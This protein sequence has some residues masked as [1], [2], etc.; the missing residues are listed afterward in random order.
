VSTGVREE[1]LQVGRSWLKQTLGLTDGQVIPPYDEAPKPPKPFI[2]VS[3]P[4]HFRKSGQDEVLYRNEAG[5]TEVKVQG[6]RTSVVQLDGFGEGAIPWLEE[7]PL[8][9]RRPSV[10]AL[11]R[12]EGVTIRPDGDGSL[13]DSTTTLAGSWERRD[14]QGYIATYHVTSGWTVLGPEFAELDLSGHIRDTA[15]QPDA[16][17]LDMDYTVQATP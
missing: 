6:G 12:S 15:Q 4:V 7:A 9:L 5:N 8:T 1:V 10:R 14:T 3:L 13:Q 2:M 17:A 11:F 16:D